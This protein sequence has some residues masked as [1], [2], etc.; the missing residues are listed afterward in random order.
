VV[1]RRSEMGPPAGPSRQKVATLVPRRYRTGMVPH[2][3]HTGAVPRWH[4][5]GVVLVWYLRAP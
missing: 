4:R 3:H 1:P 5:F 2:R